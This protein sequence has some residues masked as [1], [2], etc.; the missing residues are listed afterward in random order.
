MAKESFLRNIEKVKSSAALSE[1][2]K[3]QK[4]GFVKKKKLINIPIEWEEKIRAYHGGTLN[5]Y[6]TMAIQ[7]KMKRDGLV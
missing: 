6:I 4:L 2:E 5:A 3:G 1:Q 7:E